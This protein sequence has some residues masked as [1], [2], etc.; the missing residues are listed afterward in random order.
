MQC[1]VG[2]PHNAGVFMSGVELAA[3]LMPKEQKMP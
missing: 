2:I 3:Q 1:R